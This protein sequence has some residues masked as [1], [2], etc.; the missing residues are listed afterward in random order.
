[1]P[2]AEDTDQG[3]RQENSHHGHEGVLGP[4]VGKHPSR[5]RYHQPHHQQ[6]GGAQPLCGGLGHMEFR[7]NGWQSIVKESL[8]HQGQEGPCQKRAHHRSTTSP[9]PAFAAFPLAAIL[10]P[11]ASSPSFT[12]SVQS[13]HA[14]TKNRSGFHISNDPFQVADQLSALPL[15]EPFQGKLARGL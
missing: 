4:E 9:S 7:H 1:M 8:R 15:I 2:F 11:T 3:A 14:P 5:Y 13:L 12:G 6:I 10:I